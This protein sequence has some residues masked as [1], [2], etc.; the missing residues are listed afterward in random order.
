MLFG[1]QITEEEAESLMKRWDLVRFLR[2]NLGFFFSLF[3][4][5]NALAWWSGTSFLLALFTVFAFYDFCL[6][7]FLVRLVLNVLL[8][9]FKFINVFNIFFFS[10]VPWSICSITLLLIC[11]FRETFDMKHIKSLSYSRILVLI[12]S[13]WRPENENVRTLSDEQMPDWGR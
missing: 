10:F 12:W 8:D 1:G 2:L 6:L 5:I 7:N 4:A 9:L 3:V 13:C 11:L